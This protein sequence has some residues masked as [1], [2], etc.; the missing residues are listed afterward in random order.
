[1][2]SNHQI[3]QGHIIFTIFVIYINIEVN[4]AS[5]IMLNDFN[6]LVEFAVF[7]FL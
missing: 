1:M 4:I 2:N 6:T 5:T 3:A 7:S